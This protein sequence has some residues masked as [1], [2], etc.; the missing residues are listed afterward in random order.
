MSPTV[1]PISTIATSTS[2]R[3]S[4]RVLDL[5]GDVGD[6]LD[7]LAEVVAAALFGD[8]LL[9]DAAGGEVVIAG[10]MGV[11][12][13]FVVAEVEVGLGAVVGDEDFAVLEGRHGA[14][15]TLRY[16]SNFI[17]LTLRPRLSSRQPMEAAASPLPRKTR[18][19][20]SQRCTLQTCSRHLIL[21]G[22]VGRA[23]C[24]LPII[25]NSRGDGNRDGSG[26]R[27]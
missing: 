25:A 10:E 20:P 13:A 8:D 14:G 26:D 6:D 7:G 16:G 17:R 27:V 11:G 24:A 15:S 23:G 19:R 21:L 22:R 3:L 9:V 12:E 4:H 2:G 5:V 18:L 1:P